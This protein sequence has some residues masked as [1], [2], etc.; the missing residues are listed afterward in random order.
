MLRFGIISDIQYAP[1]DDGFNFA[2]TERRR[3]RRVLNGTAAAVRHWNQLE[4]L[5]FVAQLG[6]L[7]DRQNTELE[8]GQSMLSLHAV[9]DELLP[10]KAPLYHAI[11]Y[12]EH[13]NFTIPELREQL[14]IPGLPAA[15]QP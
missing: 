9:M 4:N 5:S 13:Y 7:V 3:Y 11:G 1:L 2:G 10:C 6:D 14:N 8:E 15:P 12:L